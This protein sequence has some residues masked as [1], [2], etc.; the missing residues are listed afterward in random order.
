M[1]K[2]AGELLKIILF[3]FLL[4]IQNIGV[5]EE[6]FIIV[7]ITSYNNNRWIEENVIS[8]LHQDYARYRVIYVDDAS[9]D[10]TADKVENLVKQDEKKID[11]TLIRNSERKGALANIYYSIH[12]LCEDDAIIVSLDGDDWFYDNQVLK[13]IN[14]AYSEKEVW[15][16]HGTF[17]EYPS[18][19]T[20]W[21]VSIP[22]HIVSRNQFRSY[23]CPSHLRTFYSWLFKKIRLEDLL[24]EGQFFSMTWDQAMMFP[25]MEMAGER[26]SFIYSILYVYNMVNPINDNK[27][28][29]QL[30]RDLEA[31]IRAKPPYQR[32]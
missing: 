7:L 32:L 15:I 24:Y 6:Q 3:A 31:L 30:Q 23:R 29:A 21:S 28:N 25:M 14:A 12:N 18:G 2:Y 4:L 26:H 22:P 8:T 11:F 13:K 16:T 20:G 19:S 1:N 9:T 17:I 10:G 5:G 27:V